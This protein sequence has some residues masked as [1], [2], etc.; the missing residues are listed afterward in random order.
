[1]RI[2]R[3]SKELLENLKS[4]GFSKIHSI[5][6]CD[7]STLYT[8]IPQSKLKSCLFQI[9]DNYFFKQKWH[10]EIHISSSWEKK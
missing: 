2:L 4:H 5:K 3:N 7:F 6:R 8:T 10:P 9:I 1:M